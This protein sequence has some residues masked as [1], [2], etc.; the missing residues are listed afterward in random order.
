[1]YSCFFWCKFIDF[2]GFLAVIVWPSHSLITRPTRSSSSGVIKFV[3]PKC[4]TATYQ[5]SNI[6]RCI[7]VW[8]VVADELNLRMNALNDIQQAMVEYNKIAL[9]N[10]DRENP[11]TFKSVRLKCNKCR[12]LA[13]P[14]SCCFYFLWSCT[15]K[16][17]LSGPPIKRT[18]SIKGTLSRVPKRT[19]D[20]SLYIGPLF[21]GHLYSWADADT[22]IS[23][24]WL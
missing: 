21:S 10:Y 13:Q 18:P 17:L 3:E 14:I 9:S 2:V 23:C 11:R 22:K 12:S 8:N 5:N 24:I 19:S 6:I 15:V 16:P 1:M 4:R 20:I 7:R